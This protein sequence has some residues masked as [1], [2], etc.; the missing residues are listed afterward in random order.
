MCNVTEALEGFNVI[1]VTG[2][3]DS[4]VALYWLSGQGQHCQFV[5]NRVRKSKRSK[6][7]GG[8]YPELR[9]RLILGAEVGQSLGTCCGGKAF[10][11]LQGQMNGP[12]TL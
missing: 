1:S 9:T 5:E 11:G 2:W 7:H 8:M 3:L 4:S 12:Q 10:H 6:S